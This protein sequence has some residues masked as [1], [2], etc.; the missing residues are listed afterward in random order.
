MLLSFEFPDTQGKELYTA[1]CPMFQR[2]RQRPQ[3]DGRTGCELELRCH[4]HVRIEL[5]KTY[6]T[7]YFASATRSKTRLACLRSLTV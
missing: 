1:P 3:S 7:F 4:C 2:A 5:K 6:G